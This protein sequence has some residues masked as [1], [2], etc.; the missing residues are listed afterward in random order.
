MK[1]VITKKTF[2]TTKP[3]CSILLNAGALLAASLCQT[4]GAGALEYSD[5]S[6]RAVSFCFGM[7]QCGPGNEG[8]D[9]DILVLRP[10]DTTELNSLLQPDPTARYRFPTS[11]SALPGSF[12][13]AAMSARDPAGMLAGVGVSGSIYGELHAQAFYGQSVRNPGL[14]SQDTLT[15]WTIPSIEVLIAHTE[16]Y[17]GPPTDSTLATARAGFGGTRYDASGT[18]I[19]DFNIFD[20]SIGI[21]KINYHNDLSSLDM[22]LSP[23]L[24]D[25]TT[26][27]G[28]LHAVEQRL[29]G[30]TG[31][32]AGYTIDE[33][34]GAFS[35]RLGPGERMDLTYFLAV[36][37]SC[38]WPGSKT[39]DDVTLFFQTRIGDPLDI[40][41]SGAGFTIEEVTDAS[42][43]PEP[44]SALL[45]GCGL[46]M[47]FARQ[48]R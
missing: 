21:Q 4:A 33:F 17:D 36:F 31:G 29:A 5:I 11:K 32:V 2:V 1:K 14:K 37:G 24:E 41:G 10:G 27:F 15:R 18:K 22:S 30:R 39:C 25:L 38:D 44:A 35:V 28:N 12:S 46:L 16:N 43:V 13:S 8:M 45:L 42:P 9:E 47:L 20:H 7:Q 48:R 26:R 3:F 6:V 34:S 23:D 19:E 40:Q